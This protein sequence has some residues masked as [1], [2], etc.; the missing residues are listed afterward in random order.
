MSNQDRSVPVNFV[1]GDSTGLCI[2]AHSE[3]LRDG[4][5]TFLT[6]AFRTF[7]TLSADNCVARI[8]CLTPCPGGSTGQ[9][10]FLSVE[11]EKS[12]PGLHHD[13]FVKFS[14]DFDDPIRDNRGKYEMEGEVRL[15]ELS[16]LSGFPIKIPKAYFADY[17]RESNTGILITERIAF[18]T[19][20]VEPHCPK[21]LDYKLADPLAHYR[22]IVTS[23]ARIAAAHKSG[24]LLADIDAYCPYDAEA[25]ASIVIPYNEQ[26]L[27][28]RVARYADFVARAPQLFPDNIKSPAFFATLDRQV[29][30]FLEHET[31]I[32]R[33][34]QSD[35]R[36]IALCHWNAN[37]DNAWFWR[38]A[39]GT[40]QCGLMDWGH[41]GQMNVAF[42]LW[43]CLSA[44][45]LDIWNEHL[46][47]LLALFICE[48]AEN[49]GPRLEMA[50]LRLHF[51]L[52]V[53]LMGLSYFI[54]SPSRILFRL[55]E[56]ATAAG[57]R[58][59]VFDKS[60]TARNQLHI[61][62]VFLNFWQ[63]CDLGASLERMLEGTTGP[64]PKG[65]SA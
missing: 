31:T 17:H 44:A 64:Y 60:E 41:A 62:T 39:A 38:D 11:Y 8:T 55:P 53:A 57:P 6:Q 21:S 48:L 1:R 61:S 16:R 25:A 22:A 3:A 63:A 36:F 30:R 5:E 19:K 27:R 45:G 43:G 24:R 65:R 9:K 28:D 12:E 50:D 52:Y 56:A 15:A 23:L 10:A 33:F 2:P 49:G 37:I 40:L 47:E 32:N 35:S 59:P 26:Q 34:L 13:L 42:S 7:G 46:E 29:G 20:G 58:D 54:D 51:E 4:G 14:R 18:G